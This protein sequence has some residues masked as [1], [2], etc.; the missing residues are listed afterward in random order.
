MLQIDALIQY[1]ALGI[2]LIV[3]ITLCL[4]FYQ[5]N[6]QLNGIIFSREEV[7]RKEKSELEEK[8]RN[9]IITMM[10]KYKATLE[11]VND[12][13]DAVLRLVSLTNA[14]KK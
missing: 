7:F 9:D 6:K 14:K 8:F 4:K 1:G 5:N 2:S 10:E 12:T 13:L 3:I 11:K